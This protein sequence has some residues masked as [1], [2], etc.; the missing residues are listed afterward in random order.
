MSFP[1][2]SPEDILRKKEIESGISFDDP[3]QDLPEADKIETETPPVISQ[4]EKSGP[5]QIR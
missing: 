1:N 5:E 4:P 2:L 3:I